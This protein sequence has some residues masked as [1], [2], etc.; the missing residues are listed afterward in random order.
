[1][2]RSSRREFL[3]QTAAAGVTTGA[4]L[5]SSGLFP[6]GISAQEKKKDVTLVYRQLGS[7]GYKVTE[8]GFGVM[9]TRDPE[10]IQAG[11]DAGIN[12][13]DT[14]NGYMKGVNEE[15][16]GQVLKKNSRTKVYV[17]T[18]VH[19]S[20]LG[21][22]EIRQMMETSLKRLQM[23]YVD[24]MFMHMPDRGDEIMNK[25]HMGVF[26]QAKKDG[27]CKFI[28][29]S[30][31]VNQ[32]DTV[33]TAVDSKFWEAVLVGYNYQSPKEVTAAMERARKAG[34]AVIAMK[35]QAKGKGYPDHKMGD[36]SMQQAALKWVLQHP[37]VDTTIPGVRAF[38][39]LA[40][41]VAV[42]GMKMSFFDRLDL[43]RHAENLQG[44]YCR[45]V[46]GCTGCQ[47]QCPMGVEICE[48]NRCLGYAYGYG[49]LRLAR[50]NYAQL[51]ASNRVD[52]CGDC[53]E[54]QVKCVNGLN[55]SHA[56]RKAKELFA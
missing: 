41:N 8:V 18:K 47:N 56:I 12:Y 10:L 24:I 21:A 49:D 50:E 7:T 32:A 45:G 29:V 14:A 44:A 11:I 30:T 35:T 13:F 16:L 6:Q 53:G 48:I 37:F 38:E 4:G 22:K 36:I 17:T 9:N 5:A 34:L 31:H 54:C 3:K 51:P 1:M 28:G 55:L 43:N 39:E 19:C 23:D 42:M 2:E 27:I 33:N 40:E 46:A 20:G 26:E 15:V 25:E 52:R